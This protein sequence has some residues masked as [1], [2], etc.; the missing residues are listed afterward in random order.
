MPVY[1]NQHLHPQQIMTALL[2]AGQLGYPADRDD[3]KSGMAWRDSEWQS[4]LFK[5]HP[6][7]LSSMQVL[8]QPQVCNLCSRAKGNIKGPGIA[9]RGDVG[10][11]AEDAETCKRFVSSPGGHAPKCI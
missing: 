2:C 3:P 6:W 9:S 1:S 7:T 11:C 10:S 5:Q 8:A 4:A